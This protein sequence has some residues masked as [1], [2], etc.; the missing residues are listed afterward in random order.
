MGYQPRLLPNRDKLHQIHRETLHH[1]QQSWQPR[2]PPRPHL[3]VAQLAEDSFSLDKY[4]HFYRA[5]LEFGCRYFMYYAKYF[6][7]QFIV[8]IKVD[9]LNS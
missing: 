6:T 2:K 8:Y 9:M 7:I 4:L 1:T 5:K 3:N